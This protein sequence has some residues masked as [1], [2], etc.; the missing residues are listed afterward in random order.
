MN[1][2]QVNEQ[3]ISHQ[4]IPL[5]RRS[6]MNIM[7]ITFGVLGI[8]ILLGTGAFA[9][10]QGGEPGTSKNPKN[11]VPEAIQRSTPSGFDEDSQRDSGPGE[12][13]DAL[14]GMKHEKPVK[15][16]HAEL[17]RNVNKTQGGAAAMAAEELKMKSHKKTQKSINAQSAK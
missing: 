11:N 5:T 6:A 13:S 15:E 14:T 17:E 7:K 16:G 10:I 2:T 8:S 4:F 12:R 9:E 3:G 1:G